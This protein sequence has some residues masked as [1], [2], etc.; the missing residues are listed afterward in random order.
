LLTTQ[1]RWADFRSSS[2]PDPES[3]PAERIRQLARQQPALPEMI[4]LPR[5]A[6]APAI[7]NF[8]LAR[9][10]QIVGEEKRLGLQ[11]VHTIEEAFEILGVQSPHFE[12]LE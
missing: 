8:G 11:V 12:P 3:I 7:S 9:M 4:A 5:I 1:S 2:I 10:F 6:V